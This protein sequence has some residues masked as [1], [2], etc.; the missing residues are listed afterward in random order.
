M[1]TALKN[2][3]TKDQWFNKKELISYLLV[4]SGSIIFA[5][6]NIK[7]ATPYGL[8]PGGTYG[9]SNVL[10]AIV[11]WKVSYLA[12]CMDIPLLIIGT[13]IL[14]PRFGFKTIL[15][16][17]VILGATWVIETYWGYAPIL[18]NGILDASQVAAMPEYM[19]NTMCSIG[20]GEQ[21]VWF[22]PDYFMNTIVAGLIYGIAIGLIFKSG[23]T[24]GGSDIISMIIN[25]YTHLPLGTLVIIVDTTIT[26]STLVLGKGFR[27]P[28]YSILLIVIEGKVI[29]I[30]VDGLKS[31][32]TVFIVTNKYDAVREVI[33]SKMK[34]GGTHIHAK[35]LYQGLERDLV[36]VSLT[37]R[38]LVTLRNLLSDA[39]PEAFVSVSD[40]SEV[41]GRGFK[42][43]RSNA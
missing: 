9:L 21:L 39:D 36:Y 28:I 14:G 16:T 29:D 6:G 15:S 19:Q 22:V 38:E 11:H 17:F 3:F 40:S 26:L 27:L 34:R 41:M 5:F 32:K 2:S 31:Y 7:F 37:R 10:N 23:A 20:Q 43:L 33:I 25:K 35:G 42:A 4:I 1:A 13:L 24:S 8:A 12:A 30:V 18:H